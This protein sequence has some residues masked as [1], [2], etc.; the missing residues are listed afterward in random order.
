MKGLQSTIYENTAQ[1]KETKSSLVM[2]VV[3]HSITNLLHCHSH[4][5]PNRFCFVLSSLS[6]TQ[7][8]K[9]SKMKATTL[10]KY[11][12]V[13]WSSSWVISHTSFSFTLVPMPEGHCKPNPP[14]QAL[15]GLW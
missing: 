5:H 6:F 7:R 10:T 4:Y 15:Q 11:V 13:Q 14:A 2:T 3:M 9:I 12:I 1:K 8:R